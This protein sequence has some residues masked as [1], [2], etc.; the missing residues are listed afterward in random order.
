MLIGA[1]ELCTI[2]PA[3]RK[4]EF[5]FSGLAAGAVPEGRV[6]SMCRSCCTRSKNSVLE[7]LPNILFGRGS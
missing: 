6:Y 5:S 1:A 7:E 3:D 4:I 2:L